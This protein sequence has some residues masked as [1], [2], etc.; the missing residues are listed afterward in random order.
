M[1][2]IQKL[3]I[4]LEIERNIERSANKM[5]MLYKQEQSTNFKKGQLKDTTSTAETKMRRPQLL[6]LIVLSLCLRGAV[7]DF[8]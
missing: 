2:E 3:N 8:A 1:Q 7:F 4:D 6:K 5:A